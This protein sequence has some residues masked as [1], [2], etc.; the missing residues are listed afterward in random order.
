MD[1]ATPTDVTVTHGVYPGISVIG[2]A[3]ARPTVVVVN[4]E[5]I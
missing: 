3:A 5:R 1:K 2:S 4:E